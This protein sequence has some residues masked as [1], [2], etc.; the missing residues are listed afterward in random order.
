MTFF[1]SFLFLLNAAWAE[2]TYPQ[3][4][5]PVVDEARLLK[6]TERREIEQW[7]YEYKKSGKAQI[8]VAIVDNLQDIPIEEYSIR[9]VEKWKLGSNVK[10]DGVLFL[11]SKNDK[12]MRIEVGQGLEGALTDIQAKRILDD[13]VRPLFK[14]GQFGAG[15]AAGVYEIIQTVDP[16]YLGAHTEQQPW[17]SEKKSSSWLYLILVIL[18][19][20]VNVSR[21]LGFGGGRRGRGGFY[22]GMGGGGWSSG[23]G[24]GWSGGGGGF[25]GGG[26][27][28]NW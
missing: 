14:A 27:S 5:S 12:K 3:L 17:K 7:L 24:G 11:I 10:D 22:G 20:F 6:S 26:A 4:S 18:I 9:L 21:V 1:L 13:R 15:I 19:I 25:S 8:Q 23:G 2:V 28:S 16:E